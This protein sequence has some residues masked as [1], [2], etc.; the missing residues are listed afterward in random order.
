MQEELTRNRDDVKKGIQDQTKDKQ[1]AKVPVVCK[2]DTGKPNRPGGI[3]LWRLSRA[4]FI[5][6]L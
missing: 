6:Q 2:A 5:E 1:T 3:S 4:R